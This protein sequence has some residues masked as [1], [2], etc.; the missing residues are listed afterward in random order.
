MIVLTVALVV[1]GMVVHRAMEASFTHDE[2]YTYLY[3]PR[4]PVSDLVLHTEP[5]TNNHLLN[6][7]LMKFSSLVFGVSEFTLRLPNVLALLLYFFFLYMIFWPLSVAVSVTAFTMLATNPYMMEL[8]SL[9]RGY[10]LS[11]GFLLTGAYYLLKIYETWRI[12]YII[13]FQLAFLLATLSSF[14]VVTTYAASLG[15]LILLWAK[16]HRAGVEAA[17]RRSL[18]SI[19][20]LTALNCMLLAIPVIQ[21]LNEKLDFGGKDGFV[22][23]TGASI[24]NGLWFKGIP[25]RFLVPVFFVITLVLFA[26]AIRYFR[27]ERGNERSWIL[28]SLV[29]LGTF[30]IIML[31]NVILGIDLP[32][33]RFALYMVPVSALPIAYA[34]DSSSRSKW[35]G[36]CALVVLSAR[37]VIHFFKDF[38]VEHSVE[39][40][41]DVS[42][43]DAMRAIRDHL[44][45][46][47]TDLPVRIGAN[48]LFEPTMNFYR[49]IWH[50]VSIEQIDRTGISDRDAYRY[51]HQGEDDGT[52]HRMA[53]YE[54]SNTVLLGR[55]ANS[56]MID[57]A[58]DR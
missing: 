37:P 7:L 35:V 39:W 38:G 32:I 16:D 47:P 2:S 49:E 12:K 56:T 18:F 13:L 31:Q 22:R 44:E 50:L 42:T 11:W 25:D 20:G 54:A 17:D 41:Y 28:F 24:V 45:R 1:A 27:R 9:A 33:Q 6:S 15:A 48:W 55:D 26:G 5:F 10:G 4:L 30:I 8:F 34:I 51:L 14:P 21:V 52:W 3:Y 29:A 19:I 43:K 57:P 36:V 23:S 40:Q 53:E 46:K 58:A